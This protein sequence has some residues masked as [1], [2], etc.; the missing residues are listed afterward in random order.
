MKNS[1]HIPWITDSLDSL[2]PF[3]HPQRQYYPSWREAQADCQQ[4]SRGH[5]ASIHRNDELDF[6]TSLIVTQ[7]LFL[8]LL[9][10]RYNSEDLWWSIAYFRKGVKIYQSTCRCTPPPELKKLK[11]VRGVCDGEW[12]Y[13]IAWGRWTLNMNTI[14]SLAFMFSLKIGRQC[15]PPPPP[16]WKVVISGQGDILLLADV[17]PPPGMKKLDTGQSDILVLVDIPPPEIETGIN[18]NAIGTKIILREVIKYILPILP[19]PFITIIWFYA[20]TGNWSISISNGYLDSNPIHHP[21]PAKKIKCSF[22]DYVQLLVIGWAGWWTQTPSTTP[23][24]PKKKMKCSFLDCVQLLMI[25]RAGRWTRTLSTTPL[26][27]KK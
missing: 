7:N 20:W 8:F 9:V 22:L 23:L 12:D 5:L 10:F 17:P 14:D 6:M 15:T 24:E 27:P 11:S 18:M 25:S 2:G 16:E 4:Y 19:P 21:S 3:L 26:Q 1:N 13:T